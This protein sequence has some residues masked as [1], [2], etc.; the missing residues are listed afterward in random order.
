MTAQTN[1]A[2]QNQTPKTTTASATQEAPSKSGNL[3]DVFTS[4][5]SLLTTPFSDL[6]FPKPSAGPQGTVT[7]PN[8]LM[9]E[10][11]AAQ[12]GFISTSYEV[13]KR[14]FADNPGRSVLY[15]ALQGA[16]AVLAVLPSLLLT[17]LIAQAYRD[18]S[19]AAMAWEVGGL[20]ICWATSSLVNGLSPWLMSEFNSVTSRTLDRE[21]LKNI[22]SRSEATIASPEFSEIRTTIKDNMWRNTDFVMK[23]FALCSSA[24]ACTIA[25]V[26]I[27]KTSALFAVTLAG[28]GVLELFSAVRGAARFEATQA[29][30]AEPR[31]TYWH[32]KGLATERDGIA[33]FRKWGKNQVLI[34]DIDEL[35]KETHRGLLNDVRKHSIEAS[36]IGVFAS[37]AK[38]ALLVSLVSN[39]ISGDISDPSLIQSALLMSLT[40]QHSLSSLITC[41]GEQR[42]NLSITA[43]SIAISKIG[44]P[45]RI[46]GKDYQ[47][48]ARDRAPIIKINDLSYRPE[49]CDNPIISGLSMTFEPGKIYGIC[50]DSGAGKTT[51]VRLLMTEL[52]YTG[53]EITIDNTAIG[54]VDPDDRRAVIGHLPQQY[55]TLKSYSVE[56]AIRI[57]E[58][59]KGSEEDLEKTLVKAQVNFLGENNEGLSAVMGGEEFKNGRAFSGGENQRIA[60]ARA[61]IAD[62]RFI[63]FDEPT[64]QLGVQDEEMILSH[65]Q[66][67]ARQEGSTVLLISHRYANLMAADKI[68]FLKSGAVLE[69]GTHSELLE[70]NGAYAS[71]FRTESMRYTEPLDRDTADG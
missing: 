40:F 64:S 47:R 41:L 58:K 62:S 66:E 71:R 34:N 38:A 48:L 25:T 54:D 55:L 45:D 56:E 26:A 15:S 33:E 27:V 39:Y 16:E 1:T 19:P 67:L 32:R 3:G 43:K 29:D 20:V 61:L 9:A 49:G 31:R 13:M 36:T 21:V 70:L 2:G 14:V 53:G 65:I 60:L 69:E 7:T 18:P 28:I 6:V 57:G 22:H 37:F 42:K 46:P 23:N 5:A 59:S 63:I 35:S 12:P 51:L 68:Y 11:Q 30:I 52:I 24:L 44:V 17:N 50:G 4:A 10:L 8:K